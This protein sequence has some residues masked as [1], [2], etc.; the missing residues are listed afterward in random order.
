MLREWLP[1]DVTLLVPSLGPTPMRVPDNAWA[2]LVLAVDILDDI[3]PDTAGQVALLAGT[4]LADQPPADLHDGDLVVRPLSPERDPAVP[5]HEHLADVEML[6]GL[7]GPVDAPRPLGRCGRTVAVDPRAHN[8]RS[9]APLHRRRRDA[10][11]RCST[12]IS[13]TPML[14]IRT[15]RV[16]GA[17]ST[18]RRS[19]L[20]GMVCSTSRDRVIHTSRRTA[21]LDTERETVG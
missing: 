8:R 5:G 4:W 16:R 9:G 18:S 7:P 11:P 10:Q 2:M 12:G 17:C 14:L 15:P 19:C 3:D 6:L 21:V 13:S 20:I 1:A